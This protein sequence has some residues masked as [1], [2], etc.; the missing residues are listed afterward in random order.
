[1]THP[2]GDDD[3]IAWLN[4]SNNAAATAELNPRRASVNPQ[5]LVCLCVIMRDRKNAV[6][7]TATPT[8]FTKKCLENSGW[9]RPVQFD[10][11]RIKKQRI[12]RVIRDDTVVLEKV[13]LRFDHL[14][15]F[16]PS[17]YR[18]RCGNS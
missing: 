18:G 12:R 14:S 2:G 3:H 8:V 6:A 16:P 10:F 5:N 17:N 1:M 9:V 4:L 13:R 11:A 7:P 15:A